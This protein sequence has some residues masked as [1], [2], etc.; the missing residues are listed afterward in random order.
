MLDSIGL[1]LC[2]IACAV[3]SCATTMTATREESEWESGLLPRPRM[4]KWLKETLPLDRDIEI[5]CSPWAAKATAG[6]ARMFVQ[7]LTKRGLKASLVTPQEKSLGIALRLEVGRLRAAL[8]DRYTLRIERDGIRISGGSASGLFYGI[9]TFVQLLD[10]GVAGREL[11]CCRIE[12]RP[13]Y[14]YRMVHYDLAREQTANMDYLKKLIDTLSRYKIN[15]LK[16]YFENRFK[17]EKHPLISPPD[18]M[19]AQ[20]ARELD[21]YARERFVEIV[22]EVNTL[23]HMENALAVKE[24]RHLAEVANEPYELCA[25]SQEGKRFVNDLIAEVSA[26]FKTKFLHVGGDETSQTGSCP[27][28]AERA[29]AVGKGGLYIDHFLAVHRMAKSRGLRMMMWGDM[30]LAHKDLVDRLP[31]DIIIFDWH[32]ENS[33]LAT[34]EFFR[35]KGFEVFVC[36]AMS[37]F[38]RISAPYL[39]ATDNIYTFLGQGKEGDAMGECTCAWE[40][41]LGHLFENDYFGIILSADRAWNTGVTLED[42]NR[43]FCKSFFGLDDTRPIDYYRMV[44]DGF[45]EIQNEAFGGWNWNWQ[46]VAYGGGLDDLVNQFGAKMTAELLEK[47][48]QHEKKTLELLDSLKRD[49]TRNKQALDFLDMPARAHTHAVR[50]ILFYKQAKE[51]IDSARS[52][53]ATDPKAAKAKLAQADALLDRIDESLNYFEKRF[54]EALKRFGSSAEDLNRVAAKKRTIQDRKA[55]ITALRAGI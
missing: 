54:K 36:P 43:R 37:G 53:A 17:F 49:V 35:R 26:P 47:T 12:D 34:V 38:S 23:G 6:M 46:H 45:G 8:A 14:R 32:Y 28:C 55:E 44:S 22:P 1:A 15:M 40:L 21:E 24:Y 51:L 29:K 50:Q 42:F 11:P 27:K 19:T 3:A 20:Q 41:R 7:E 48:E 10:A 4:V 18:V 9:Q 39:H 30:L 2:L 31:K 33:S 5:T 16:L 13:D 25:S 52:E